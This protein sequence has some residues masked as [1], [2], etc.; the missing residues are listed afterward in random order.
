MCPQTL[1][2]LSEGA[3]PPDY[4]CEWIGTVEFYDL[5]CLHDLRTSAHFFF[6]SL[7]CG[8]NC[9]HLQFLGIQSQHLAADL[10]RGS[11]KQRFVKGRF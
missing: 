11:T 5:G 3:A 9:M 8:L 7:N 4:L 6:C 1:P 2:P 10:G